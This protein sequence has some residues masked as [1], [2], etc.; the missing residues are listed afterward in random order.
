MGPFALNAL[1][2]LGCAAIGIAVGRRRRCV[3]LPVALAATALTLVRAGLRWREDLAA[4]LF[5]WIDYPLVENWHVPACLLGLT[6]LVRQLPK[7]RTRFVVG[8]A[9]GFVAAYGI[10]LAAATFLVSFDDLTGA[11]DR[12]GFCRQTSSY[13]CGAAALCTLL[14]HLD[15]ASS[16]REL[17]RL[18]ATQ[19]HGGATTLGLWR[20]ARLKLRNRPY[21]VRVRRISWDDLNG[22]HEKVFFVSPRIWAPTTDG[23]N[24]SR[25]PVPGIL[26]CVVVVR[27]SLLVDHFVTVLGVEG[28]RVTVADPLAPGMGLWSREELESRWRRLALVVDP[29]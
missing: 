28:S 2:V 26:P 19:W 29:A 14:A 17:A 25:H 20:A 4:V 27:Y 9:T 6:A 21:R 8:G 18:S 5:P 1:A 24:A 16:E 23:D 7:R 15:V 13:S 11:P 12:S 10:W 22:G 3:W